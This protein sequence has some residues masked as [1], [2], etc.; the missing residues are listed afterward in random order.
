MPINA[1]DRIY[2]VF[3]ASNAPLKLLHRDIQGLSRIVVTSLDEAQALLD[4]GQQLRRTS[5]T[6]RNSASSRSHLVISIQRRNGVGEPCELTIAD[7]A[8]AERV[9]STGC[10]GEQLAEAGS[11]NRSLMAVGRCFEA[12][13]NAVCGHLQ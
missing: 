4:R 10:E 11:I 1:I 2:D 13:Q 3:G 7:L 9:R 6:K 8:G 12:L 5:A